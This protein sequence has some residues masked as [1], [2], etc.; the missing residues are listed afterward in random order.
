MPEE[1]S[2]TEVFQ[3][4][5]VGTGSLGK[6][7][8]WLSS[9]RINRSSPFCSSSDCSALTGAYAVLSTVAA[10]TLIAYL[11]SYHIKHLSARLKSS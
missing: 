7:L 4:V 1:V 8:E 10:E 9:F 5:V 3:A 2:T 6:S 11:I